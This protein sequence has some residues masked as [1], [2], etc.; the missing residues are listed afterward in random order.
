MMMDEM[1]REFGLSPRQA[2]VLGLL[3]KG[4]DVRFISEEFV[5][6]TSTVKSHV[7]MLYRKLGIHSQQELISLVDERMQVLRSS[8]PV[9]ESIPR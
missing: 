3:A 2:E 5:V 8:Q 7:Y 4:R 6:S 1:S 9:S